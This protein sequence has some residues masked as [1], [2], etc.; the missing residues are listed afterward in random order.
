M[1]DKSS[2]RIELA[3]LPAD[4]APEGVPY[5]VLVPPAY[6]ENDGGAFPLCLLL[7]GGGGN[8]ENLA[9]LKPLFDRWWTAGI[10][11]PMVIASASTGAMS[12]YLDH[13]DGSA[14]WESLIAE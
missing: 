3:D 1:G 9:A 7:H 14:R 8:R 4:F 13:P 2:S 11:P 5:A 10:M 6:N 12:Y